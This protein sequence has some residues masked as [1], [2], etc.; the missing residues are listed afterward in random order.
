MSGLEIPNA[1]VSLWREERVGSD[2]LALYE[3]VTPLE[4]RSDQKGLSERY[5]DRYLVYT[6]RNPKGGKNSLVGLM[7]ACHL[8][9]ANTIHIEIIAVHPF[10]RG[11]G[12]AVQLYRSFLRALK[13]DGLPYE[14]ISIEGYLN[15]VEFFIK[16]L[17][18]VDPGLHKYE[19]I[20]CTSPVRF[21]CSQPALP[22]AKIIL[23]EWNAF[24]LS[25]PPELAHPP[26]KRFLRSC[27]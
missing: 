8:K 3:L 22:K 20:H 7:I 11:R 12:L 1:I 5:P 25:W 27:L 19:P 10:Y 6:F 26:P 9:S 23:Q 24:A 16:H 4:D 14:S 13:R 21:L 18:L 2:I 15:N 17:G